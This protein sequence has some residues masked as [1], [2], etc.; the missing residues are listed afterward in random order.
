MVSDGPQDGR[1]RG[2]RFG[3]T[4]EHDLAAEGSAL[5][6]STQGAEIEKLALGADEVELDDFR[7]RQ[8]LPGEIPGQQ[9]RSPVEQAAVALTSRRND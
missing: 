8:R 9:A 3:N 4:D 6:E 5:E 2:V 1:E 7:A